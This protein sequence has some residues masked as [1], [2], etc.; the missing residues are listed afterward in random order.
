MKYEDAPKAYELIKNVELFFKLYYYVGCGNCK[1]VL[2]K[3]KL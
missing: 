2:G 1:M 3:G